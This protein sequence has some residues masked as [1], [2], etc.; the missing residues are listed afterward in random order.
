MKHMLIDLNMYTCCLAW[1]P[2]SLDSQSFS[3]SRFASS[4]YISW[5]NIHIRPPNIAFIQITI[6]IYIKWTLK[7]IRR[8]THTCTPKSFQIFHLIHD[9]LLKVSHSKLSTYVIPV[10][11]FGRAVVNLSTIYIYI[12]TQSQL[13]NCQCFLYYT[14]KVC[15]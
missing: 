6:S 10:N 7:Y 4:T 11:F 5:E 15:D 14:E 8:R 2:R 13:L 12:Y 1:P 9:Q 3:A